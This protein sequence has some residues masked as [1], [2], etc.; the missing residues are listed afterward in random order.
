[1]GAVFFGPLLETAR[2]SPMAYLYHST[3]PS[4]LVKIGASR[5]RNGSAR[6]A[7]YARANGLPRDGWTTPR[8]YRMT[9]WLAALAAEALA[10][11]LV[12][13]RAYRG[14]P[15]REVFRGTPA[16]AHWL[17]VRAAGATGCYER[18]G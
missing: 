10:H 14:L 4:G 9:S 16:R 18:G 2:R 1:L 6:I 8:H 7:D 5:E 15:G 11:G 3:H 12:R 13:R 17:C